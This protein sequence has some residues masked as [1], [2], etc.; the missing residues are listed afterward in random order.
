MGAHGYLSYISP[1]VGKLGFH[2]ITG[3][4]MAII[5]VYIVDPMLKSLSVIA[6]ALSYAL[7]IWLINALIVLPGLGYG[8][9]GINKLPMIGIIYFAFCHV[10]FFLTTAIV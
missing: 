7:V 8:I 9:A 4:I 2:Y 3:V 10:S 5:Y 1:K 6:R